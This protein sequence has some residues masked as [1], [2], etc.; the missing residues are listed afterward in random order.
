[1]APTV[2]AP[3]TSMGDMKEILFAQRLAD[4][5]KRVRDKAL[6]NLKKYVSV[7]TSVGSGFSDD[8]ALKIWKGL[9]YCMYM[10]DKPLI[11]EDL[12]DE[13]SSLF[14]FINNKDSCQCFIKA[15]FMTFAREWNGIDGF[16]IGKFMMFV[17]RVVRQVFV[18]LRN[19]EWNMKELMSVVTILEMTVICPEDNVNAT[20][21]GLKLHL[22]DIILEELAKVGG[23]NLE[24]RVIVAILKP[25]FKVLALTK[26]DVYSRSVSDGV[27]RHLM[28]QS[29]LGVAH[30]EG[31]SS[32][33]TTENNEDEEMA[34]AESENGSEQEEPL[35][36]RAGQV[37][38]CVPQLKPNFNL[39]ADSLQSVGAVAKI[40]KINRQRI[41]QLASELRDVAQGFYP[42]GVPKERVA[43]NL[44]VPEIEVEKAIERLQEFNE[45]LGKGVKTKDDDDD[46]DQL[47]SNTR[48]FKKKI[49]KR[50]KLQAS[51]KGKKKKKIGL[52]KKEKRKLDKHER[53]L[54]LNRKRA[55][56][57]K[58]HIVAALSGIPRINTSSN[59]SSPESK[60]STGM[61]G[62]EVCPMI[63]KANKKPRNLPS[64]ES[65]FNVESTKSRINVKKRKSI[66]I[67]EKPVKKQRCSFTVT[68]LDS[69]SKALFSN[70]LE[71]AG[72]KP[73]K[74]SLESDMD[75]TE[76]RNVS[77]SSKELC[78][79]VSQ[80]KSVNGTGLSSDIS[81]KVA[82][83]ITKNDVCEK[84]SC[85]KG[86]QTAPSEGNSETANDKSVA[87]DNK[88]VASNS[89]EETV[90]SLAKNKPIEPKDAVN[91][92]SGL[93]LNFSNS[94]EPSG[95]A[96]DREKNQKSP[97]DEPLDDGEFEIFIKSK[98]Q[99]KRD[100]KNKLLNSAKKLSKTS[101]Q[102]ARTISINLKQNKEHEFSDYARTLRASPRI[103][104]NASLLPKA[105]VLKASPSPILVKKS[106]LK[107]IKPFGST[108]SPKF[109]KG[110]RANAADFFF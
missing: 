53:E 74:V 10:A 19:C 39:L 24:H 30:D 95:L 105:P 41:Y 85:I 9:F 97:W 89:G 69:P 26:L 68:D 36:P 107:N 73:N 57:H 8:D 82:G 75:N 45:N 34:D 3:T 98:R 14:H 5:E 15:A 37:D 13:I 59:N 67:A 47:S 11:Q 106:L 80:T 17:R 23:E 22:C 99:I 70:I 109:K 40:R 35:D 103:P 4:N 44:E 63:Q 29:S 54:A 88:S 104:F 65:G 7:K 56:E 28:R 71:S 60:V 102:K 87:A 31:P 62:F 33:V 61:H 46:I 21:L 86:K 20:P 2:V 77:K 79:G 18:Y 48:T 55:I 76:E 51:K 81:Y 52:S 43:N 1:M 42:L 78:S 108:L 93:V 50:K 6:K 49:S 110:K 94:D 92:S 16:R 72:E 25:Y 64:D 84:P 90:K 83:E 32:A 27:I 100:K 66:E 101:S 58:L 91:G 12:A 38:V 96:G